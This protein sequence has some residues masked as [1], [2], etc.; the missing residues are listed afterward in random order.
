[1]TVETEITMLS[2]K[3]QRF[4]DAVL[5]LKMEKGAMNQ[6]MRVASRS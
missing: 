5:P 3:C 2:L 4:E 6:G 1:M